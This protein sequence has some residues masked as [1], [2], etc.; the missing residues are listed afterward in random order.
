MFNN[1]HYGSVRIGEWY[2][3]KRNDFTDSTMSLRT[4]ILSLFTITTAGNLGNLIT[5]FYGI[6]AVAMI[7]V[8]IFAFCF[9]PFKHSRVNG[10]YFIWSTLFVIL[11][12][13][14]GT[15]GSAYNAAPYYDT[16]QSIIKLSLTIVIVPLVFCANCSNRTQL[17]RQCKTLLYVAFTSAIIC[18]FQ[19]SFPYIF[20]PRWFF[21]GLN[22][23]DN[24]IMRPGGLWI[25]P[26]DTSVMMASSICLFAASKTRF[27]KEELIVMFVIIIGI[28]IANTRTVIIAI[29]VLVI[30]NYIF[31]LNN[32]K[33]VKFILFLPIIILVLYIVSLKFTEYNVTRLTGVPNLIKGD[34]TSL[35]TRLIPWEMT[36]NAIIDN[37]FI[38]LGHGSMERIVQIG[39][40]LGPHNYFLYIWGTSGLLTVIAFTIL[41]SIFALMPLLI[42]NKMIRLPLLSFAF[43]VATALITSHSLLSVVSLGINIG[44]FLSLHNL[45]CNKQGF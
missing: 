17:N 21:G 11:F 2:K 5:R 32:L 30:I 16:A 8:L 15:F 12:T 10:L 3:Q 36:Y 45:S 33:K 20:N 23:I 41:F 39:G 1:C 43:I 44:V 19:Q 40:G 27:K 13:V 7:L 29:T 35:M 42:P 24:D 14:F 34:L 9:I 6:P 31:Y 25:N 4:L 22:S 18:I 26:N 38:G 37:Y 28:F